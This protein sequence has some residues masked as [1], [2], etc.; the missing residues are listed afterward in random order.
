MSNSI[1]RKSTV[2]RM[3]SPEQL[4]EYIRVARPGVWLVLGAIILLLVGVIVWGVSGTV[5]TVVNTA[6]F[7]DGEN[8]P[9]CFVRA[10]DAADI[11]PGMEMTIGEGTIATVVSVSG[12]TN[13]ATTEDSYVLQFAGIRAGDLYCSLEIEAEG[14]ETGIYKGEIVVERIRP[15]TF[16]TQ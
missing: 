5:T 3:N 15:I 2:D 16:V 13:E 4:N 8:A 12:E 10:G 7:A 6:V 1:F 9:M 14:L 11:E